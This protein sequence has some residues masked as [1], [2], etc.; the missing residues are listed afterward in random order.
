MANNGV[1]GTMIAAIIP[2]LNEEKTIG[3]VIAA[4]KNSGLC[5]EIIVVSDGSTDKTAEYAIAAGAT[6]VISNRQ[7]CGKGAAL[8][9]GLAATD[10]KILFFCDADLIGIEPSHIHK[11]ATPVLS[12]ECAMNVG[13]RDRGQWFFAI[14]RL[15]PLLSGERVFLRAI[16]ES[17]PTEVSKGYM[18]EVAMNYYCTL[19]NLIIQKTP[20]IG[21]SIRRKMQKIGF[22]RGI[23]SY[24][25]MFRE[26]FIAMIMLRAA[27]FR[28]KL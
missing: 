16:F 24:V 13:L 18:V 4:I 6:T 7:K 19:H 9:A 26:L 15:L 22:L 25:T 1:I 17:L 28:G 20:L 11:L 5:S 3:N 14:E 23:L 2:A 10:A 8:R 27:H 12:G 21:L